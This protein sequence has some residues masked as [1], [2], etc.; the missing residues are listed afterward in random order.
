HGCT[1]VEYAGTKYFNPNR[2]AALESSKR[3]ASR[4]PSES[5]GNMIIGPIIERIGQIMIEYSQL[6]V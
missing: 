2:T 1:I 4:P 5:L 3:H 6:R